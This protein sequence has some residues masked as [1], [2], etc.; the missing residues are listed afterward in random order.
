MAWHRWRNFVRVQWVCL[1]L[2]LGVAQAQEEELPPFRILHCE[3]GCHKWVEPTIDNS[4]TSSIPL[5]ERR[6]IDSA[7]GYVRLRFTI[8]S[9]GRVKDAKVVMLL[10]PESYTKEALASVED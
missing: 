2:L 8:G 5:S 10:G 9:D 4:H 3:T 7:E 1:P 6:F